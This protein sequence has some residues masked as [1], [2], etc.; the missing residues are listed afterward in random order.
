MFPR[1]GSLEVVEERVEGRIPGL[2]ERMCTDRGML[3]ESHGEMS[4]AYL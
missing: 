2:G 1:G 4:F 3:G